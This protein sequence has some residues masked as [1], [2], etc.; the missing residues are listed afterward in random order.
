MRSWGPRY[1]TC[2]A[3]TEVRRGTRPGESGRGKPGWEA[4]NPS[5]SPV[6]SEDSHVSSCGNHILDS[7]VGELRKDGMTVSNHQEITGPT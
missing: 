7:L 6:R 5:A 3:D 4:R 2:R 1:G